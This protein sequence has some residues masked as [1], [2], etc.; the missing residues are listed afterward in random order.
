MAGEN[1]D[2]TGTRWGVSPV[3]DSLLTLFSSKAGTA[4]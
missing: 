1:V 3:L 2:G 4:E